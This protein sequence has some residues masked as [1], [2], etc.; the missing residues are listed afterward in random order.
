MVR[1]GHSPATS[2]H[3]FDRPFAIDRWYRAFG[4]TR[5]A[6]LGAFTAPSPM[7]SLLAADAADGDIVFPS[8]AVALFRR[9]LARTGGHR[10]GKRGRQWSDDADRAFEL[11][12]LT[13]LLPFLNPHIPDVPPVALR[14]QSSSFFWK[15]RP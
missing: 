15:I 4:S 2:N 1:H 13:T 5:F 14:S 9:T 8:G 7:K 10:C 11:H 12:G 6:G 3:P